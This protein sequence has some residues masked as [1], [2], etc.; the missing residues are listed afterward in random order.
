MISMPVSQNVTYTAWARMNLKVE[1]QSAAIPIPCTNSPMEI[2][3][4]VLEI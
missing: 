2:S 1:A 4:E 3:Q